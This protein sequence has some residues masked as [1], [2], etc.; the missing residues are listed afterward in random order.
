M[1]INNLQQRRKL[2]DAYCRSICNKPY[3]D[4]EDKDKLIEINSNKL[5]KLDEISNV[6]NQQFI[7]KCI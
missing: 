3:S 5:V 1:D 2:V 6:C 7:N 4:I